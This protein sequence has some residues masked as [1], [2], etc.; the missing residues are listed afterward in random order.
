MSQ[1]HTL[2]TTNS[3][4]QQTPP[5]Q[6]KVVL[7]QPAQPQQQYAP[8]GTNIQHPHPQNAPIIPNIQHPHPQNVPIIP[9]IQQPLSASER[10]VE[11]FRNTPQVAKL[12]SNPYTTL[13][14]P[15]LSMETAKAIGKKLAQ[16]SAMT[17][18]ALDGALKTVRVLGAENDG[19]RHLLAPADVQQVEEATRLQLHSESTEEQNM[20]AIQWI[21]RITN[22]ANA[23]SKN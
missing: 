6:V 15:N 19:F 14:N 8:M 11:S 4:A 12:M 7:H 9:N 5:Q 16:K 13:D 23:S 2:T 22:Y 18:V 17:E 1:V 10:Y 20:K 21:T 3:N